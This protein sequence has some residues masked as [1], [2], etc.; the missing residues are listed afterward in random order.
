MNEQTGIVYF[1]IDT[2]GSME[3]ARIKYINLKMDELIQGINNLSS[4]IKIALITFSNG[5]R[6]EAGIKPIPVSEFK[7]QNLSTGGVTDI[8][9]A[10][11]ILNELLSVSG[12]AAS[13]IFLVSDGIPTDHWKPEL[14]KLKQNEKFNNANKIAITIGDSID[15]NE[16][17]LIDFTGVKEAILFNT[18]NADYLL[19]YIKKS[20]KKFTQRE[21]LD[22]IREVHTD[23]LEN[24]FNDDDWSSC[25][26]SSEEDW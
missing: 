12:S 2:S 21:W 22:I 3:G 16:E 13:L 15:V 10:F 1:I 14:A 20:L 25:D 11:K 19:C 23:T 24:E 18:L 26:L 8:G 6:L 4:D 7:W 5:A 17:H 9:A